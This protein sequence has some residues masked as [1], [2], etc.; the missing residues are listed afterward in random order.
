MGVP[1]ISGD[2]STDILFAVGY[3]QMQD[4]M[5]QFEMLR[6]FG[7]G[8]LSALLGPNMLEADKYAR[9]AAYSNEQVDKMILAMEPD[10]RAHFEAMLAGIN[11]YVDQALQNPEKYLPLEFAYQSLPVRRYT[12]KDLI[13]AMSVTGRAYSTSGGHEVKNLQL[14]TDLIERHGESNGRAIF[15]DI[16][17]L[18]DPDA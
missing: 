12:A 8:E 7:A 9:T 6:R 5:F 16:I 10:H 11:F 18:N 2:R 17:V 13:D 1:H 4:R 14:L 15:D 3:T